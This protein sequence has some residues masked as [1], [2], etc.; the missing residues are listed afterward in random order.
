MKRTSPKRGSLQI[1][2]KKKSQYF[3]AIARKFLSHRGAP[4]FLSSKDLVLLDTWEKMGIPLAAVLEGIE[5]A[6]EN[7][8]QR[9]ARKA[10]ILS[11]SFC[12]LHV[13]RAFEQHRERR[14][15]RRKKEESRDT[16]RRRIKAE[17]EKFLEH[18]PED[19][20]YLKETF[21]RAQK[22]LSQRE[23]EEKELERMEEEIE[24]SLFWHSLEEEKEVIKKGILAEYKFRG[25]EEFLRASKTR[26]IKFLR[27]KYRIPYI[28]F[29]YY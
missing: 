2:D 8:R 29:Y 15:G 14:V 16:K 19:I 13:L 23:V 25:R 4:F 11:L 27:D 18:L 12:N 6:F 21:I 1:E 22:I 20:V 3:Q 9:P 26:L 17:V 28:S 24:N 5:K 7:L 10:K